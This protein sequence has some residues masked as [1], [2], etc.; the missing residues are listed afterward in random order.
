M[1]EVHSKALNKTIQINRIIGKIE[2]SQKGPTVVFVA[3]LHGNEPAGIFA[4]NEVINSLEAKDVKGNIYAISGNL[5][6]L[7][8]GK[9]FIQNDLNRLWTQDAIDALLDETILQPDQKEQ[10]EIY[11]ILK[12]LL[13]ENPPPFYFIDIHTTSSKTLPFITINDALINRKFS[14]QFPVPVVLGIE[15]YLEGPLLTYL[16]KLGYVSLGF[17]A[18]QHDDPKAITSA[19]SFIKLALVNAG[20]LSKSNLSNYSS[21]YNQLQAEANKINEVFEVTH[22]YKLTNNEGFEMKPGFRSFQFVKKGR[23]LANH[24]GQTIYAPISAQLFMP[25]YQAT[26]KEGFFLIKRINP[27]FLKLSA[28]LRNIK[29][30]ALLVAL[31]GITWHN[32]SK[33][34]LKVNLKTAKFMAKPLFHLL[35]YRNRAIDDTF[36]LLYNRERVAQTL[37]YKNS[38]WYKNN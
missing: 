3:G 36:V 15:E 32:K 25:L 17:E 23:A 4:L 19:I 34:V 6:A 37:A 5:V 1:T 14:K 35:G 24:K 7:K 29:V 16:N 33:G 20:C 22:L 26:G 30:D 28:F 10:Y 21:H 2:G 31:P 12:E 13:K 8:K 18:G 27:F 11:A 9:R 38:T